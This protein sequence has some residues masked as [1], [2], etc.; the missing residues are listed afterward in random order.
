MHEL[1]LNI[2]IIKWNMKESQRREILG[3]KERA[4]SHENDLIN[5]FKSVLINQS[6]LSFFLPN[7]F[8]K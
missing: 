1:C 2:C 7:L 4:F 5:I 8:L 3:N 6:Q